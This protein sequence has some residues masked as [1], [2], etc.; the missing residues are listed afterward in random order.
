MV[1][2]ATPADVSRTLAQVAEAGGALVVDTSRAFV[3]DLRTPVVFP[4]VPGAG[5]GRVPGARRFRVP[6][7]VSQALLC[8]L[9]PLRAAAGLREVHCSAFISGSGGGP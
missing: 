5:L 2:L 7:P 6:G 9:E 1:L 8:C 3:S 4:R